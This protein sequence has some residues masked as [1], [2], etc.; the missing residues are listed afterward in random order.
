MK[1]KLI[2]HIMPWEI[3]YALLTFSQ[4]KKSKYYISSKYDIEIDS[5]LNL[6]N[7]LI[8]WDESKLPKEF[9]IEKY[10]TMSILLKDYKHNPKIIQHDELYGHLDLQ[11]DAIASHI[12]CYIVLCP[13]MYFHEH[14]LEYM[15]QA[16]DSVSNEYF[17]I[18][19][20]I[21]RMWDESWEIL[22]HP[23]F[24]IGP[25]YGWEHT[26]DIFDVDFHVKTSGDL[27]RLSPIDQHKWAG[28][29]DL[30]S[31]NFYEKLIPVDPEW[32]GY[33]GWDYYGI[34]VSMI[35]K[36]RGYDFQ[37]YRLDGQIVFEYGTGPLDGKD[38]ASYYKKFFVKRDVAEQRENFNK[39][40]NNYI[41]QRIQTL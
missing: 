20:Q 41:Q 13:D 15:L 1:V 2:Y 28:W 14:L 19:P 17:V 30:Y 36:Q 38:F 22:T 9:F 10:N 35:A 11:R 3:D 26:T 24:A 21:C 25:H 18:T 27:V 32:S 5:A 31:K 16:A 23:K 37:Q 34:V 8:N 12:D 29:F 33:G 6:S 7:H 40:I 39:N 4:L